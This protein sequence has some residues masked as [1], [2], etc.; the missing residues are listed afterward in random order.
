MKVYISVDMEGIGGIVMREQCIK[1]NPYYEEARHL[2]IWEANAAIDG[3]IEAGASEV[4]VL[5]AHMGGF[6]FPLKELHPEA[7]FIMGEQKR[8]IRFPFLD[9][10]FDMIFLQGYHAM[11]GTLD[12]IRDH[13]FYSVTISKVSVNGVEVGE[14]AIDALIAGYFNVPVALVTG[15]DKVCSEVKN[16][17]TGVTTAPVKYGTGRHCGL[18][19]P[20]IKA[21]EIVKKAAYDAVMSHG[22]YKAY[23]MQPPY[24][25]EIEYL[26]TDIAD[27]ISENGKDVIRKNSRTVLY[28]VD[29]I[30]E[31]YSK[32]IY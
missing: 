1:G 27:K 26:S 19:Y 28:K 13:T 29:S 16:F 31:I 11:A 32:P 25:V 10:T 9:N 3:A 21:R 2:M 4:Y 23:T 12:A 7:K 18:I 20:P 17:L 30:P 14:T 22:K 24:I 6:N 5:D 8:S 15:D